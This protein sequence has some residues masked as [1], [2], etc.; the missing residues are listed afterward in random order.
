VIGFLRKVK[1]WRG[2][3]RG[4]LRA[5]QKALLMMSRREQRMAAKEVEFGED[6]FF[7]DNSE[8][9]IITD[10]MQLLLDRIDEALAAKV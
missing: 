1:Q 10:A 5:L 8:N 4:Y 2:N 3:D 6:G 7:F 9:A